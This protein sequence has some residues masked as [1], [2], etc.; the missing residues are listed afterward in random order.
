M[1]IGIVND[2][3]LAV[4]AMRRVLVANGRHQVI[5]IARD[6]VEAVR[7]CGENTPDLV[8]MD[9]I[10]PQ[11]DGVEATRRIMSQSPCAILVVTATVDGN[12][13]RV[14][15]ALGAGAMDA[16]NTPILDGSGGGAGAEALL[17]KIHNIE[18]L[19]RGSAAD[20][21]RA[22]V[23]PATHRPGMVAGKLVAIGASAGGPAAVADVLK[24]MPPDFPAAIVVVQH[25]DDQFA[26]GLADWLGQQTRLPVRL[27]REGEK[28]E[29]GCVLVSG[30]SYH[31]SMARGGALF[32]TSIPSDTAYRPSVDVFFRALAE[33]W[34]GELVGVL[35]TGMGKDGAAGLKELRDAGHHTIAQDRESCAVY[36]MPKAAA[37]LN[38]AVEILPLEKVGPALIRRFAAVKGRD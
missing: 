16:V 21:L 19:I 5:W 36:G 23:K 4:E 20:S 28:P 32:Y 10:M 7:I 6:G 26:A 3:L 34:Q 35:L 24:V 12:V 37:G 31:L 2:M 38:A 15:E 8:L 11:M 18:V 30:G 13:G 33:R 25:V 22:S 9:L 14:F 29:A 27:A 1:R 17:A